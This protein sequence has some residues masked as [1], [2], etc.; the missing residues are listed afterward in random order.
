MI[1][2]DMM[3]AGVNFIDFLSKLETTTMTTTTTTQKCSLE[4]CAYAC[5]GLK[6]KLQVYK[7]E[8]LLFDFSLNDLRE[9]VKDLGRSGAGGKSINLIT[10]SNNS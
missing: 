10:K 4:A 3:G 5:T 8:H 1:Q 9:G 7:S 2:N 6:R